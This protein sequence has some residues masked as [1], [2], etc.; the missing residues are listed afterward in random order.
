MNPGGQE[1][2]FDVVTPGGSTH[3]FVV[4][5]DALLI[6]SGA[7]CE[8]RLP[9]DQAEPE[10]VAVR[11]VGSKVFV[12]ARGTEPPPQL[13]GVVFG[14]GVLAQ[15]SVLDIGRIRITAGVRE[16]TPSAKRGRSRDKTS[17]WT[18]V[19]VAVVVP[20][21]LYSLLAGG[22]EDVFSTLPENAPQ[23]WG[24]SEDDCPESE[25]AAASS[26][27]NEYRVRA[28]A[29]DERRPFHVQSGVLA[30]AFYGRAA[31]CYRVVGETEGA[32]L[33]ERRA[34]KLRDEVQNDYRSHRVR[35]EHALN[36]SDWDTAR[37]EVGVLLKF[38]EGL[39]GEYVSWLGD[40]DRQ[41]RVRMGG[42]E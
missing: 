9:V 13:D 31:A 35:L 36:V 37:G 41:F 16:A 38:T 6:G 10:H 14:T 7:H 33:L 27:A 17:V 22:A 8:I 20:I 3:Q 25:P 23:L 30:V 12:E 18:Y 24:A 40:L 29:R 39:E 42:E 32:A 5:N 1:V 11:I 4:E 28:G 15:G 21:S 2:L 19:A 34:S 26:L